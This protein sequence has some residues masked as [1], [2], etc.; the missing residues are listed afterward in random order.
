MPNF[1]SEGGPFGSACAELAK[2]IT[3]N[4]A[5]T[6]AQFFARHVA[7]AHADPKGPLLSNFVRVAK[8][9]RK[10]ETMFPPSGPRRGKLR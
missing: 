3:K 4:W 2:L 9:K 8:L 5:Y 1:L 7:T 10:R 6:Y